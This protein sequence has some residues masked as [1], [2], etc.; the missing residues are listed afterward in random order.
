MPATTPASTRTSAAA[1]AAGKG[2]VR[3]SPRRHQ[4]RAGAGSAASARKSAGSSSG[5]IGTGRWYAS[6]TL[7]SST[8]PSGSALTP[9]L[10]EPWTQRIAGSLHAHLERRDSGSGDRRDLAVLEPF[11]MLQEKRLPE[12][13]IQR[14]QRALKRVA[15]VGAR[16]LGVAGGPLGRA[17]IVHE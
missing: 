2:S 9:H 8:S 13:W 1:A 14:V 4:A 15:D 16:L 7:R 11:A 17:R 10:L 12:K 5:G 6:R 3:P